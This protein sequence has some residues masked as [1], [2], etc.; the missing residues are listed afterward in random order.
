MA[1]L[2]ITVLVWEHMYFAI[3]MIGWLRLGVVTKQLNYVIDM[4]LS[5]LP[6]HL[7]L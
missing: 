5:S 3:V 2:F 4:A 1:I 7:H 6:L